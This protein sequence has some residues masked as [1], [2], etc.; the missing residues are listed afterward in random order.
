[1]TAARAS[2]LAIVIAALIPLAG[3]WS[4]TRSVALVEQPV[5]TPVTILRWRLL[6]VDGGMEQRLAI[7][8]GIEAGMARI[9]R[10]LQR[11]YRRYWAA[12]LPF[13]FEVAHIAPPQAGQPSSAPSFH[14][15]SLALLAIRLSGAAPDG[16]TALD[17]DATLHLVLGGDG[18]PGS[19]SAGTMTVRFGIWPELTGEPGTLALWD[20]VRLQL[21]RPGDDFPHMMATGLAVDAATWNALGGEAAVQHPCGSMTRRIFGISRNP[22][23]WLA[24]PCAAIADCIEWND[25]GGDRLRNLAVNRWEVTLE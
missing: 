8:R 5:T 10:E 25:H 19:L 1:M 17:E 4:M 13:L 12:N 23:R 7:E 24:I 21:V 2:S 3:C 18:L 6:P 9:G 22:L 11:S 15:R 14:P 20:P 16:V